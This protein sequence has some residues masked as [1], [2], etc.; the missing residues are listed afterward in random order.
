MSNA[1]RNMMEQQCLS[2]G[3]QQAFYE[4]LHTAQPQRKKNVLPKALLIAAC[5]CLLI[6]ATALAVEHI[7]GI[8]MVEVVAGFTLDGNPGIGYETNYPGMSS[9]PLSDFPEEIQTIGDDYVLKTYGSWEEA[10]QELGIELMDNTVL[11]DESVTKERSYDLSL[12]GIPER[13]HCF[14]YYNG[15]DGRFYRATVTAAYRYQNMN[16]T[17]QSVVTVDHPAIS[18]EKE[19]SMH[20]SGVMY[21]SDNV[22]NITQEQ[23]TAENGIQAT[24]VAVD[25][26]GIHGT[27]YE[28][29]FSA[30]GASYRITVRSYDPKLDAETKA[31]LLD[32]LEGFSF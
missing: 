9:R 10:E 30:N 18:E 24:V 5:I 19:S 13:Q 4:K 16:I 20:W 21:E 31:L 7:F 11:S 32:I 22:E 2:D 6:P 27:D 1:Y 8:S 12:D 26:V 3:A 17:V 15:K 29:S 23:Y 25:W 28:A 14:A